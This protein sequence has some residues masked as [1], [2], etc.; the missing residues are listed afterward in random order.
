M[1]LESYLHIALSLRSV[2][3]RLTNNGLVSRV[4]AKKP[5]VS[6]RNRRAR[7]LWA[8][9]QASWDCK[10][11]SRVAFSDESKFCRIDS[12]A[13]SLVRRRKG[14]RFAPYATV[15]SV[16]SGGGSVTVWGVIMEHLNLKFKQDLCIL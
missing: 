8:Q 12:S 5:L 10:K 4:A 9:K 16:Q 13:K 1:R 15:P 11:W 3:R 7:Q 14:E 2:Q 6:R